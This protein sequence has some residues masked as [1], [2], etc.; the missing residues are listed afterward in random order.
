MKTVYKIEYVSN[1]SSAMGLPYYM[2]WAVYKVV[3]DMYYHDESFR[4][5]KEAKE[6]LKSY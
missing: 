6:Y 2:K 1:P 3:G 4:T 5:K